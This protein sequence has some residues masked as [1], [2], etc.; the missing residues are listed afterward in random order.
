MHC[1]SRLV[2]TVFF[3]GCLQRTGSSRCDAACAE[4]SLRFTSR[5]CRVPR[6]MGPPGLAQLT[7]PVPDAS[8]KNGTDGRLFSESVQRNRGPI[9]AVLQR[10]LPGTGVV[11][12]IASG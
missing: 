7:M 11:L 4:G 3:V 8:E 10:I 6:S 9:L 5:P 12:E 1:T 2:S